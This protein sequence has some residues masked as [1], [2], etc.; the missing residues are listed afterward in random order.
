[1]NF[2][3]G[4]LEFFVDVDKI[5]IANYR[6]AFSR[7]GGA[8][9]AGIRYFLN[10]THPG[11]LRQTFIAPEFMLGTMSF[12]PRCNFTA[13]SVQNNLMGAVFSASVADRL[14]FGGTGFIQSGNHGAYPL[15]TEF[16][17]LSGVSR[18]YTAAP[19]ETL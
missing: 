1:M 11:L 10:I 18:Y 6:Y 17:S 15:G 8:M 16:L 13:I 7:A 12:D 3:F 5:C 14:V 9:K 4:A 2:R 19:N